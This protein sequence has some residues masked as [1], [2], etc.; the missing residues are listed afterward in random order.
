MNQEMN[1]EPVTLDPTHLAALLDVAYK[2]GFNDG[3]K[4]IGETLLKLEPKVEDFQQQMV[5]AGETSND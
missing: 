4:Q 5:N 3:I 2:A 1:N